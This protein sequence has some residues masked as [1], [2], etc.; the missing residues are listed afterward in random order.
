MI[1]IN[2]IWYEIAEKLNAFFSNII[3]SEKLNIEV[4]EDLL[5][6]AT[7]INDSVERVI[8]K[9]KN[10]PSIK[11]I[12]ETFDSNKTFSFGLVSPY[13]IFKKIISLDTNYVQ[14]GR[15]NQDC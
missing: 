12:Q 13:T 14:Q 8:Q 4:K 9:H 5:R 3:F 6:D 10:H 15:N 7:I 11:M 2:I 1:T